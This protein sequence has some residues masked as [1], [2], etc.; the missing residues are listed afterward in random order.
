MEQNLGLYAPNREEENAVRLLYSVLP[1]EAWTTFSKK[2]VIIVD[3]E[4][5][6]YVLSPISQTEIRDKE[7]GRL[8][9]RACLQLSIP[10]PRYDRLLA[11]YLLL[12]NDEDLY[13][14]TANIFSQNGWDLAIP[15]LIVGNLVLFIN[16]LLE[17]VSGR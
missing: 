3:G 13:W 5:N 1:E 14:K 4:R 8:L 10:A 17:I 9:A 2:R 11:E 15:I 6:T 7:T 16:L 12:K